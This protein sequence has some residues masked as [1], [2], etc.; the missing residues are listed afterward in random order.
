MALN[1]DEF[2]DLA[3]AGGKVEATH[4]IYNKMCEEED[5]EKL[6][7]WLMQYSNSINADFKKKALR[8]KVNGGKIRTDEDSIESLG[9]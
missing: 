2:F 7:E 5:A 1:L 3:C 8:F 4:D 6:R 9:N